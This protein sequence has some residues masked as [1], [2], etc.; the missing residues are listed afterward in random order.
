MLS[1][2]RFF[3]LFILCDIYFVQSAS[4]NVCEF[5]FFQR[6][7][8]L[9]YST[10]MAISMSG[11]ISSGVKRQYMCLLIIRLNGNLQEILSHIDHAELCRT[12]F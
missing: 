3:Y 5:S 10:M 11:M 9:F 12:R 2:R 8:Q 7:S 4:S 1:L 6:I